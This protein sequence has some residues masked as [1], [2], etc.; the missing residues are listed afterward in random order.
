MLR[1]SARTVETLS[2]RLLNALA[3]LGAGAMRRSLE[4]W[5]TMTITAQLLVITL[6]PR[7]WRSSVARQALANQCVA[8][9]ARPLLSYSLIILLAAAVV[10]RIVYVTARS[11]GLS[12]YAIEMLVRVLVIELIPLSAAL[13]VAI[14]YTVTRGSEIHKA[15]KRGE[16]DALRAAGHDPIALIALPSALAGVLATCA[17]VAFSSVLAMG[18]AYFMIYG[19]SPHG[20]VPYMRGIGK[21]F[22]PAV[23]SVF[24]VKT[25]LFAVAVGFA[26][27][28]TALQNLSRDTSRV[29]VALEVLVRMFALLLLVEMLSLAANYY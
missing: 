18:L 28:A 7:T 3:K 8:A 23:A 10:I 13:F 20:V 14:R 24:A 16:F 15:R 5:R 19:I 12:G 25:L 4:W 1:Q 6:H 21:V 17:L 9:G 26:P 27:V 29:G 2:Q 11:Y 22:T